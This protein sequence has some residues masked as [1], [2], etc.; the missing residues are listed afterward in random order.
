MSRRKAVSCRLPARHKT[1]YQPVMTLC[2]ILPSPATLLTLFPGAAAAVYTTQYPTTHAGPDLSCKPTSPG[3]ARCN[4]SISRSQRS[5]GPKACPAASSARQQ[6]LT[7]AAGQLRCSTATA[8][9]WRTL[10][11]TSVALR[12]CMDQ[13]C[14]ISNQSMNCWICLVYCA[15]RQAPPCHSWCITHQRLPCSTTAAPTMLPP[16]NNS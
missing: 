6:Q 11:L 2:R 14:Q 9:P 3:R 10:H 8:A 7:E 1:G 5:A 15:W 12:R 13:D 16:G 4:T